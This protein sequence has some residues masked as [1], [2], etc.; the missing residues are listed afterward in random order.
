MGATLCYDDASLGRSRLPPILASPQHSGSNLLPVGGVNLEVNLSPI[1]ASPEKTIPPPPARRRAL[2]ADV[3]V[4]KGMNFDDN[5][6]GDGGGGGGGGGG[7]GGG[8]GGG[9]FA[10]LCGGSNASLVDG[11]DDADADADGGLHDHYTLG[12]V[13]GGGGLASRTH[14]THGLKRR[15][16]SNS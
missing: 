8:G 9:C 12:N 16:V 11:V 3:T 4:R 14:L 15:L 2:E 5:G 10:F 1:I 13:I 6:D 7:K